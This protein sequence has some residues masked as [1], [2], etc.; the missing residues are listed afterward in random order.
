MSF[1]QGH[2]SLESVSRSFKAPPLKNCF[3]VW[4]IKSVEP[5]YGTMGFTYLSKRVEGLSLGLVSHTCTHCR[6]ILWKNSLKLHCMGGVVNNKNNGVV[7]S[8]DVLGVGRIK[9]PIK[10]NY[11]VIIP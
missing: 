11:K 9:F 8:Q 6:P 1:N 10:G 3:T 2:V 5:H 7:L 4:L